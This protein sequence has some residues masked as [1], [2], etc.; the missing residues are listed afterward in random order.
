[1]C[2]N[3]FLFPFFADARLQPAQTAIMKQRPHHTVVRF[4]KMSSD[5]YIYNVN[6]VLINPSPSNVK[7]KNTAD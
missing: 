3:L 4:D 1:M 2:Q 5:E 6:S 7:G